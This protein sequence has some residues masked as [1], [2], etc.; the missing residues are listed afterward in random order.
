[1]RSVEV[2]KLLE[3]LIHKGLIMYKQLTLNDIK[4]EAQNLKKSDTGLK[5]T[6][7]LNRI[8]QKYGYEK[9]EVLKAKAESDNGEHFILIPS[10]SDNL[11]IVDEGNRYLPNLSLYSDKKYQNVNISC[12]SLKLIKP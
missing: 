6:E 1:M 2:I 12:E 9:F 10:S 11:Y 7:A 3:Q 8:A 4:Q 5:H